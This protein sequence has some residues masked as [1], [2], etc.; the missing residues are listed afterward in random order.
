MEE[1]SDPT[2]K[3]HAR[4]LVHWRAFV[5]DFK[6]IRK[7]KRGMLQ[8]DEHDELAASLVDEEIDRIYE[9]MHSNISHSVAALKVK[10]I[11]KCYVSRE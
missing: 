9:S 7:R 11:Q 10:S 8:P 2:A 3:V 5:S 1:A 4:L 6:E